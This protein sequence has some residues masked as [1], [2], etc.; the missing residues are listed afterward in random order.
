ML[1]GEPLTLSELSVHYENNSP[2]KSGLK[3]CIFFHLL[4][5]FVM[6]LKLSPVILDKLD[7]FVLEIEELEI[8]K[9]S[10]Y[11]QSTK[12]WTLQTVTFIWLLV[13]I[14]GGVNNLKSK[15]VHFM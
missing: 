8:P 13:R 4:L 2:F 15:C 11:Q 12:S 5:F 14:Y 1:V 3:T 7:V 9:V 6:L 10:R